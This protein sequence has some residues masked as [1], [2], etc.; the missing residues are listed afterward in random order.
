MK[1]VQSHDLGGGISQIMLNR[2]PVNA[3]SAEFLMEF[4]ETLDQMAADVAIRAVVISS[5]F[6]MLSAGLDL[7][8]ALSFDHNDEVAIVTAL[9]VAFLNLFAFPKPTVVAVNGAAI[10]GGLFF[11]LASDYRVATPNAKFGLAE[12]RV[13]ADFPVGPMEI[14]RA[15]LTPNDLRRMMLSGLPISAEQAEKAGIV[16]ALVSD[17]AVLDTAVDAAKTLAGSPAITYAKI[18]HQI[19]GDVI[20]RIQDAMHKG[21]NAPPDGWFTHETKPAMQRML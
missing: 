15:T 10:A 7:K 6:K 13:G 12:V 8:E 11:V 4:S 14:A 19:R 16:D 5:A 2:A 18:K 1:Y 21:A 3:L 9:N 17:Q 20:T